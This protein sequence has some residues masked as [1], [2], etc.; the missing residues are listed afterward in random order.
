MA[1]GMA[2]G[3][4]VFLASS[5]EWFGVLLFKSVKTI[6]LIEQ[7]LKCRSLSTSKYCMYWSTRIKMRDHFIFSLVQYNTMTLQYFQN[8]YGKILKTLCKS[9]AKA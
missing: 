3:G 9:T 2:N 6:F 5:F 8:E 1:I 7:I 4:I